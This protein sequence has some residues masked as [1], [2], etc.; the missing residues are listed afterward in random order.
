VAAAAVLLNTYVSGRLHGLSMLAKSRASPGRS[1]PHSDSF[2]RAAAS[3]NS[4]RE[5]VSAVPAMAEATAWAYFSLSAGDPA[6]GA[7]DACAMQ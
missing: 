1:T 2:E 6:A 5:L 4:F 7:S 3:K